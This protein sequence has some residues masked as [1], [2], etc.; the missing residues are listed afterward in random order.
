MKIGILTFHRAINYGAILQCY[1]LYK[2]LTLLGHDVEVIDY[3]PEAIEQY[4]LY[5][6]MHDFKSKSSVAA[7]IRYLLSCI[8]QFFTKR[9]LNY[10]FD[11][12]INENFQLSNVVAEPSAIS[13]K[14]DIIFFGS[15]QIWN[16]LICEGYDIFYYGQFEKGKTRFVSYAA[17]IGKEWLVS[18]G[19]NNTFRNCMK[20]FNAISVREESFKNILHNKYKIPAVTVC[21][22]SQ[23]LTRDECLNFAILPPQKDYVLL[24]DTTRTVGAMGFA[25]EISRQ[26]NTELVI[27]GAMLNRFKRYPHK[28]CSELSPNEWIGYIENAKCIVTDSFHATSFSIIL[29]KDFYTLIMAD[30]NSRSETLL[31]K[32]GLSSRMVKA[33]NSLRFTSVDYSGIENKISGYSNESLTFITSNLS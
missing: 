29:Q 5:F 3:R 27:M 24:F 22:P 16:P 11:K 21:D 23:F 1:G 2:T 15:D 14:Y 31:E 19:K 32:M 28:I 18:D 13:N 20:N 25:E 10:I 6:R 4:R 33:T 17:S 8:T 7:K 12:F 30:N 26:L 9:K